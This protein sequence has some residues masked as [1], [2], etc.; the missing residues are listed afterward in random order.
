MTHVK[1]LNTC[2]LKDSACKGRVAKK[3]TAS[4]VSCNLRGRT[5]HI[6]VYY[7]GILC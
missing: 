4:P 1:T 3:G 5:A 7:I 6:Y 2:T